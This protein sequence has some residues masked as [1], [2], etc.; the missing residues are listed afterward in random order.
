MSFLISAITCIKNTPSPS[1]EGNSVICVARYGMTVTAEVV[2][3]LT[4][5]LHN[6]LQTVQLTRYI[7]IVY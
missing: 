7:K 2:L 5:K 3:N 6:T 1:Q 4:W